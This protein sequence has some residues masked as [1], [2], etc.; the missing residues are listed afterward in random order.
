MTVKFHVII[1]WVITLWYSLTDW[2]TTTQHRRPQSEYVIR[3]L[4]IS[5]TQ[6]LIRHISSWLYLAV[7]HQLTEEGIVIYSEINN[8]AST[9]TL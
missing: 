5:K 8:S 3:Y 9:S 4:L 2:Q 1:F 7:I 6:F